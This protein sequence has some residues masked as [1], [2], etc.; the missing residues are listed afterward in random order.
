MLDTMRQRSANNVVRTFHG[1]VKFVFDQ[2]AKEARVLCAEAAALG[3]ANGGMRNSAVAIAKFKAT[4]PA[5]ERGLREALASFDRAVRLAPSSRMD[6]QVIV[7]TGID[8]HTSSILSVGC[9]DNPRNS[10][11]GILRKLRAELGETLQE[12]ANQHFQGL[13]SDQKPSWW[14]Q[15]GLVVVIGAVVSLAGAALSLLGQ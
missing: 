2:A 9:D 7:R 8:Q 4:A 10:N 12:R 11:N 13:A 3:A 15:H 6:L 5:S 1:R 14:S